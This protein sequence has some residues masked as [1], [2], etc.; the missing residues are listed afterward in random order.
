MNSLIKELKAKALR[1]NIMSTPQYIQQIIEKN[2][3]EKEEDYELR[4]VILSTVRDSLSKGTSI[5]ALKLEYL[6]Q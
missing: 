2:N 1:P 6:I 3:E 4:E 5:D